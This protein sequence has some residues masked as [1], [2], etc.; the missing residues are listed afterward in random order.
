M[1]YIVNMYPGGGGGNLKYALLTPT[2]NVQTVTVSGLDFKPLVVVIRH[3]TYATIWAALGDNDG[4]VDII[5]GSTSITS[6]ELSD[7][8]FTFTT[9]GNPHNYLCRCYVWGL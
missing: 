8:G 3:A 7:D 1:A 6:A 5:G 2:A 9:S 4:A